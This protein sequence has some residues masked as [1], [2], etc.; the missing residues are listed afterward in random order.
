[1]EE[2]LDYTMRE[3]NGGLC[4]LAGSACAN[5]RSRSG[6][7]TR[8]RR[9][10]AYKT[11][12]DYRDRFVARASDIR[13]P[14]PNGHFLRLYGQSDREL[15]ENGNKD[16]SRHAGAHDDEWQLLPQPAKPLLRHQ[17]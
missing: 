11:F 1:M 16:A 5:A 7:S 17:P 6:D 14:A 12:A 8:P 10:K 4:R 13:S 3:Q 2:A 15:V 9:S